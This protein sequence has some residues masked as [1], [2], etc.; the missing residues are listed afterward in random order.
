MLRRI[1]SRMANGI[2]IDQAAY[3]T[4]RSTTEQVFSFKVLCEK[5]KAAQ[6]IQLDIK[7][8]DMSKAFD[9]IS[10]KLLFEHLEEDIE[11]DELF[12]QSILANKPELKVRVGAL[13]A[14]PFQTLAGIMQDDC[15]SA[16]LFIYYLGNALK[17]TSI[18]IE[19]EKEGILYIEPH[20]ICNYQRQQQREHEPS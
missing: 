3:Q 14:D 7:M 10:R 5:A 20:N 15:L 18:K 2:P 1:W 17:N 8:S 11:P 6:L 9:N 12:Y 19:A 16:L 4:G 13:L